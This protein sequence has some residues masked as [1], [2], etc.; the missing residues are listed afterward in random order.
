MRRD[1]RTDP[2][3][4]DILRDAREDVA[5]KVVKCEVD[6][7]LVEIGAD[8]CSW[9]MLAKWQ[10]WAARKRA[11]TVQ[12]IAKQDEQKLAAAHRL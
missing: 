10:K 11:V 6:R 9:V 5:R 8:S 12:V 4:G 2:Q 7:L 1:P 3:P